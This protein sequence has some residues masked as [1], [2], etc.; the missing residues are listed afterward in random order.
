MRRPSI[1]QIGTQVDSI[2]VYH[3][4]YKYICRIKHN[5]HC[6]GLENRSC[7][8]MWEFES[9]IR[10]HIKLTTEIVAT[11]YAAYK[12]SGSSIWTYFNYGCGTSKET[13]YRYLSIAVVKRSRVALKNCSLKREASVIAQIGSRLHLRV[14]W[15]YAK[16][17]RLEVR[18]PLNNLPWT[19]ASRT[20][21]S[22]NRCACAQ[23]SQ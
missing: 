4:C 9:L 1:I 5:W 15:H 17:E 11:R 13:P 8:S 22:R 20:L 7:E 16:D 3:N 18:T 12:R 19:V 2:P 14:I 10:R 21:N 6:R 23:V